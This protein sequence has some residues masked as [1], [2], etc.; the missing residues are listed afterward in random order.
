MKKLIIVP[1][2]RRFDDVVKAVGVDDESQVIVLC[3][4]LCSRDLVENTVYLDSSSIPRAISTV[5]SYAKDFERIRVVI[6]ASPSPYPVA[7]TVLAYI[8]LATVELF[9]DFKLESFSLYHN[10]KLRE[11]SGKP[12]LY[13]KSLRDLE[14][15]KSFSHGCL[16]VR[17]ISKL[18]S[19]PIES[20]RRRL[21]E[22]CRGGLINSFRDSRRT[23]Y[24]S[25]DFGE[26]FIY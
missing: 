25:T 13:L 12:R 20:A 1:W 18:T 3:H 21:Y 24:C 10:G 6:S 5:L 9:T 2:S 15:I 19:I 26:M 11:F 7:A 16:D 23:L 8:V 14:I 17:E 4:G 22:L